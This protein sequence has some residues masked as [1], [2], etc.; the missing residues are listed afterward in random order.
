MITD[1]RSDSTC[2]CKESLINFRSKYILFCSVHFHASKLWRSAVLEVD[3]MLLFFFLEFCKNLNEF[4]HFPT[5]YQNAS[6]TYR[7]L[8]PRGIAIVEWD[9][10]YDF[11][12]PWWMF[13]SYHKW[14]QFYDWLK[15]ESCHKNQFV[16]RCTLKN[17][18]FGIIFK[19]CV[20][21]VSTM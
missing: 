15:D 11:Q 20:C 7:L 16:L 19:H 3:K 12:T 8:G 18:I 9:F 1:Q 2:F 10:F 14:L 13:E 6:A 5:W 4:H 21:Y 17:E